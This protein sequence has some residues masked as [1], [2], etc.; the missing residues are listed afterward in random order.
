MKILTK[1]I[2]ILGIL[3]LI[4]IILISASIFVAKHIRIKEIVEKQIEQSL[5]I[6]VTIEKITFSPLLAHVGLENVTIHNPDGFGQDEL[7]YLE[8]LHF[9]FDPIEVLVRKDS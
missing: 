6:K 1:I 4:I 7:A 8:S 9:L 2:F 3:S 5:G